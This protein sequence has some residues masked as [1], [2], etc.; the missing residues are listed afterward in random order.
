MCLMCISASDLV[1]SLSKEKTWWYGYLL[2]K[3]VTCVLSS[4]PTWRKERTDSQKL[5][6]DLHTVAMVYPI[7]IN[8]YM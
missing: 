8:K 7:Q 6:S 1:L 3:L 5:F 2:P 4:G